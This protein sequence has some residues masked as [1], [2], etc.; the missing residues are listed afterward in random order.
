MYNPH[1]RQEE[2][3]FGERSADILELPFS[4]REFCDEVKLMGYKV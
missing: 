4:L 3:R 2:L 1:T